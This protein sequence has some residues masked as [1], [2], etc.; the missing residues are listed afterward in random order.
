MPTLSDTE[1]DR[2][3]PTG[4]LTAG[5]VFIWNWQRGRTSDFYRALIKLILI[6]DTENMARINLGFPEEVLAYQQYHLVP[7]WWDDLK[8][9]MEEWS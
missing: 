8:K 1:T 5:E 3:K 7:G 2:N 6:A 4:S 9:K